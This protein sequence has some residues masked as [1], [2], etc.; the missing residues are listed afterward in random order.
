VPCSECDQEEGRDV[1]ARMEEEEKEER[2][3]ESSSGGSRLPIPG[4]RGEPEGLSYAGSGQRNVH[5]EGHP[6]RMSFHPYDMAKLVRDGSSFL[7]SQE[8][9]S[10]IQSDRSC[11]CEGDHSGVESDGSESGFLTD[12][13]V[14]LVLHSMKGL[15]WSE[16]QSWTG[17]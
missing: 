9:L 2:G 10:L 16:G 6:G 4:V 11:H 15:L 14:E 13:S 3:S 7:R 17:G 5:S 8:Q 12:R 1:D